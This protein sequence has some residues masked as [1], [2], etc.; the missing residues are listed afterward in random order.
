MLVALLT[1]WE[2][3]LVAGPILLLVAYTIALASA[4][5]TLDPAAPLVATGLVAIVDL[6]AWSLELHGGAEQQPLAH[7]RTLAL[8]L[9]GALAISAIVTV[10]GSARAGAGTALV[11]IGAAAAIALLALIARGGAGEPPKP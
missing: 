4:S 11:I 8:L 2:N 7:L 1:A 10:I 3:A 6:G 9:V 5:E